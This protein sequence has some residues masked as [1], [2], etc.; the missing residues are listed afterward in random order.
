MARRLLRRCPI[1]GRPR[2]D[3]TNEYGVCYYDRDH[4][5]REQAEPETLRPDGPVY[6]DQDDVGELSENQ[7]D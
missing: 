4:A 1:C 5:A 7:W 6:H 3:C 2:A